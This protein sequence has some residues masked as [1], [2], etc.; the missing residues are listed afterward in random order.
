MRGCGTSPSVLLPE[1]VTA[2][3][4]FS[5]GGCNGISLQ[6]VGPAVLLPESFRGVAPSA[7]GC[8]RLS[9]PNLSNQKFNDTSSHRP[10]EC[11]Y[12]LP[13]FSSGDRKLGREVRLVA[14]KCLSTR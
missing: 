5:F 9:C 4:A 13:V 7:R 1:S 14:A 3:T 8:S 12:S 6:S 10:E 11:I 2:K